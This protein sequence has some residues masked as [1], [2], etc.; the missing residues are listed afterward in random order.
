MGKGC[1]GNQGINNQQAMA[2]S[3]LTEQSNGTLTNR[4]RQIEHGKT[5]SKASKTLQFSAVP[6]PY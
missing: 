3:I 6:A 1:R 5:P 2:Q 4:L